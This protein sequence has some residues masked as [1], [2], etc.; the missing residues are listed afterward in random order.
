MLGLQVRATGAASVDIDF[1]Q[2]TAL[3]SYQTIA[4]RGYTIV[5]NG[6]ITFNNIENV[7]HAGGATIYTPLTGPLTLLPK[8]TQRIHILYDEGS[9]MNVSRSLSVRAFIRERRLTV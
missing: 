8:T 3:D 1:I 9:S 5:N 2:L 7:F 4:Q 6:T